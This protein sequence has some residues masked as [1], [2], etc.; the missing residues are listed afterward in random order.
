MMKRFFTILFLVVYLIATT[1]FAINL[2]Y[3]GDELQEI[4]VL[5]SEDEQCCSSNTSKLPLCCV[6]DPDSSADCCVEKEL[7]FRLE[8]D[9]TP[10]SEITYLPVDK[11]FNSAFVMIFDNQ[12]RK[13]S[14]SKQSTRISFSPPPGL[15]IPIKH[16]SLIFYG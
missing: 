6:K 9:A 13:E 2:Q 11:C 8:V 3:C 10:A 14:Y 15:P 1:G 16:C 5:E 12:E 4:V 7:F